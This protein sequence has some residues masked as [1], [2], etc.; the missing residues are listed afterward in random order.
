VTNAEEPLS[1]W[2]CGLQ[3]GDL[4]D[5]TRERVRIHLTDAISCGLAGVTAEH[6]SEVAR[7]ADA[8]FGPGAATVLGGRSR[9]AGGATLVNGFQIAAP[10]LGD[11][12]RAT[13]THV[14]PEVLPA[15]LAAAELH[16]SSGA[17]LFAGIAAGLEVTVRVAE[18]L[19]TDAYDARAWHNPG[20][21]GAVGA[22]CAAAR[23][24][25]LDARGVRVAI[26]HA[27]SQAAGTFAALG[28]SGVK[29]HQARGGLSGLIAAEL[30]AAGVDAS[31]LA[32]TAQRGG[33]LAAYAEGGRP[34]ALLDGLGSTYALESIS[35]R[36]WPGA[37]SLQPVI[38]ATLEART[39]LAISALGEVADA[40]V[41][42]PPRA[43]AMNG[44]SGWDTRLSSLQSA[45]WTAAVALADGT[46]WLDQTADAR[47]G[48]TEVTAFATGHVQ[49]AED[50]TLPATGARV[51]IRRR[52]G[53]V[54][55]HEVE[56]PPGDPRRPL[57]NEEVGYKL[58]RA[59]TTLGIGDRVPALVDGIGS[60]ETAQ[61]V[62][63]LTRQLEVR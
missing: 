27:A 34:E 23:V 62:E 31:E 59:A 15:A 38:D 37:S 57:T 60:I 8:V 7:A 54:A 14:M 56:V 12:H 49:V 28:T 21:A 40:R 9:A 11:V 51:I 63:R 45:R 10:T 1:E 50:P 2:V 19:H 53:R 16:D 13:L 39:E 3:P 58:E 41:D 29:V 5:G 32:L 4:P 22:A 44:Q 55:V 61:S 52:D 33:L 47:R 24:A 46:M 6:Q 25:R 17:D 35:L 18:A 30:A 42:L 26:G 36:R 20:I 48:D 43:Y